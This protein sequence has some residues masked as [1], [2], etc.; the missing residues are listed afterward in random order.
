MVEGVII[1]LTG[2]SGSGKT[3]LARKTAQRLKTDGFNVEVIDGDEY[4]A[5]VCKDLG[6]SK[7]NRIE[8]IRRL[9][10]IAKVLARNKIIVIISAINPYESARNRIKESFSNVL[11]IYIKC[12]LEEL[13]KR[14]TKGLYA[15]AL[16]PQGDTNRIDNFTGISDVY[17]EPQKPD[18]VIET[19]KETVNESL[20]KMYDIILRSVSCQTN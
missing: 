14:D 6:F 5:N 19:D 8:N 16:L 2:M 11:T 17:E 3:T 1:Q 12:P 15:R 4:R 10:F 7:E 13:E 18:L 9:G 20:K